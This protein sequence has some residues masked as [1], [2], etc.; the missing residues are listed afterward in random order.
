MSVQLNGS[1]Q[2][3]SGGKNIIQVQ[4]LHELCVSFAS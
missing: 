1:A 4:I 2:H 3:N